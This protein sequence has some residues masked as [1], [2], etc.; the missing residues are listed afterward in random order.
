PWRDRGWSRVRRGRD[1]AHDRLPAHRHR[2][3]RLRRPDRRRGVH[4]PRRRRRHCPGDAGRA[5]RR[6]LR[7]RAPRRRRRL[8]RRRGRDV[9]ARDRAV[10]RPRIRA[11]L[12][13]R[14]RRGRP[15]RPGPRELDLRAPE[16]R[17]PRSAPVP[18]CGH[19][20]CRTSRLRDVPDPERVRD[21]RR[22]RARGSRGLDAA[23][24]SIRAGADRDRAGSGGSPA[25]GATGA[26][27]DGDRLRRRRRARGRA[28]DRRGARS[29]VRHA[30]RRRL[31]TEGPCG[32]RRRRLRGAVARVR[33]GDRVRARRGGGRRAR[34]RRR[35]ARTGLQGG[36][37]ARRGDPAP[38][39]RPRARRRRGA[40]VTPAAAAASALG[41]TRE[42]LGGAAK[43]LRHT[44]TLPLS[45]AAAVWATAAIVLPFVPGVRVDAVAADVYLAFAATAL[46]YCVGIGGTPVLG[47]GGFMAVGAFA[48]ALLTVRAGWPFP[49]AALAGAVAAAAGG[50]CAGIGVIRLRPVFLAASTWLLAWLVSL[51][52][53]AFPSVSGGAQGLVFDAP[54][55]FLGLELTPTVHLEL[56]LVLL[57]AAVAAFAVLG[58]ARRGLSLSAARQRRRDAEAL[59][60]RTARLRLGAFV[61]GAA[62]GGLAGALAADLAGVAD[63]SSFGIF[64]SLK[65]FVAVIVGG[66]ASALGPAAG[67]AIV[68]AVFAIAGPITSA[69]GV[70]PARFDPALAAVLLLVVL[71]LGGDGVVPLLARLVPLPTRARPRP[72]ARPRAT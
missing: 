9:R 33:G 55:A 70:E 65:L 27:A 34:D 40:G 57:A 64:L 11:R 69:I 31:R 44:W 3:L 25:R 45:T 39:G 61:G 5:R 54:G 28:R 56:A 72:H 32:G 66:A 23:G 24:D 14:R 50:L 37:S 15:R 21:R 35:L 16:L 51:F 42:A 19:R 7:A 60:V 47:F 43:D 2:P 20:R 22:R 26:P 68:V 8:P 52:L 29:A 63:P 59:G 18:A 53:G 30:E 58:R 10:P 13:R 17:L 41:R 71:G 4:E 38:R 62:A 36:A 46:G 12:D 49:A 48:S 67:V 1:R 6:T